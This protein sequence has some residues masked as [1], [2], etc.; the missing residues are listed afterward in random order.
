[1]YRMVV[2][3]ASESRTRQRPTREETR[4]RVL[5]GA[6]DVFAERGIAAASI[7]DICAAVG[8]T[9]GAFYSSFRTK[10]ELVLALID[11]H[12]DESIAELERLRTV[13]PEPVDFLRSMESAERRRDGVVGDRVVLS[14]EFMLYALRNPANRPRLIERQRRWRE[15]IAVILRETMEPADGFPIP[16]EEA[17]EFILALDDGYLLH[18]LIEPG[19]YRPG[20][21]SEMLELLRSLG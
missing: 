11:Q 9:R 20:Q 16:V 14:M 17:A 4:R 21:F 13:H 2:S 10:D 19:S 5:Q 15:H 8:L 3:R 12:V 18:E 1:M 6:A 7:E